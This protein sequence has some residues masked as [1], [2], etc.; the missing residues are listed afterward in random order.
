MGMVTHD[1]NLAFGETDFLI[2]YCH[3]LQEQIR[4]FSVFRITPLPYIHLKVTFSVGY[5]L[6]KV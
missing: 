6:L 2:I 4:I 3:D 1:W 5:L